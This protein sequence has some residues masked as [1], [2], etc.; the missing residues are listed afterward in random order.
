MKK[1]FV[2]SVLIGT[3]SIMPLFALKIPTGDNVRATDVKQDG[4]AIVEV[5]LSESKSATITTPVGPVKAAKGTPVTF[6]KSG[7]L[8]S[9]YPSTENEDRSEVETPIGKIILNSYYSESTY[10]NN[11]C[12]CEFYESG[13]PK[14]LYLYENIVIT[15]K[16]CEFGVMA[17]SYSSSPVPLSFYDSGS[18]DVWQIES[19]YSSYYEKN[20]T[21]ID[22][23]TYKNKSGKFKI[24]LGERISFWQDGSIKEAPLHESTDEPASIK[25]SEVFIRGGLKGDSPSEGHHRI[26]FF[27]DGSIEE[28]I[29]DEVYITSQAGQKIIVPAGRKVFLQKNGDIRLCSVNGGITLKLNDKDC[30][31]SGDKDIYDLY[32]KE[33]G[34][35]YG[36]SYSGS[37]SIT[38]DK[39]FY[40]DGTIKQLMWVSDNSSNNEHSISYSC[41]FY[42][43]KRKNFLQG[44]KEIY[45]IIDLRSLYGIAFHLQPGDNGHNV[46]MVYFDDAGNPSSYT[47]F[48]M[49]KDG[50]YL[51]DKNGI[52]IE[53]P[54]R[55]KF[56]EQQ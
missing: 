40:D 26:T 29:P 16:N 39:V 51:L 4:D 5:M 33:D 48:K 54:T 24:S 42:N 50:K 2:L 8:K 3:F 34:T 17:K 30:Y 37:S 52:P 32:F 56:V 20:G 1:S 47:L 7:A 49:D 44:E 41:E 35:L 31:I 15:L 6:Y 10:Y 19:F 11:N 21:K 18:K 43:Q 25:G 36:Y 28:F 27:E 12:Q 53:D 45:H 38:V 22:T 13:S 46:A 23:V 9:F 14:K 55:K